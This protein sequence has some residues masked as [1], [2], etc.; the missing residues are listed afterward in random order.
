M[1]FNNTGPTR[2]FDTKSRSPLYLL[3]VVVAAILGFVLLVAGNL[4]IILLGVL[5]KH[6]I[7]VAAVFLIL[8]IIKIK[9]ARKK[10][11]EDRSK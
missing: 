6:W 11:N 5:I 9:R 8:I 1:K 7:Y 10:A 2:E 4:T 3:A